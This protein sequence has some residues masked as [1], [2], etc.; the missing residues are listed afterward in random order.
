MIDSFSRRLDSTI[1]K[2]INTPTSTQLYFYLDT[3]KCSINTLTVYKIR[4][5]VSDSASKDIG[6]MERLVV[7]K[8]LKGVCTIIYSTLPQFQVE[9]NTNNDYWNIL[10]IN[11]LPVMRVS[12]TNGKSQN[13]QF[14]YNID[15]KPL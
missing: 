14:Y 11:N 4:A 15:I 6:Y 12:N 5:F 7:L 8:N 13:W 9:R 3:L 1:V 2:K 10:L